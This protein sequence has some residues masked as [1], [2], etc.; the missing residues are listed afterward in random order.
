MIAVANNGFE[1]H[2]LGNR[3]R[4]VRRLGRGGMADV[5]LATDLLENMEVAVKVLKAEY[6]TDAE[7]LRRFE[8]EARAVSSLSHPNIVQ[9]YGIG[10]E[11]GIHYMVMEYIEGITLKELLQQ[12]VRLDW[13]A[14]VPIA[15]Q[16]GLALE[17]AHGKG[18]IHRDIKPQNIMI[19]PDVKAKVTDF[20]IAR[21][22]SANTITMTGGG[23]LGSVHYFSPEQARGG[24]VGEKSDIYSLGILLYELVTGVLPFDGDTSVSIAIKHLQENPQ[25]PSALQSHIPS[26]LDGIIMKCIQKSPDKRYANAGDLIAELDALMIDPDG[27]YGVLD[28]AQESSGTLKIGPVRQDPD[29]RKIGQI[30]STLNERRRSRRRDAIIV[31]ALV[32]VATVALVNIGVIAWR[33]FIARIPEPTSAQFEVGNYAGKDIEDVRVELDAAGLLQGTDFKTELVKDDNVPV[34]HVIRQTPTPGTMIGPESYIVLTLTVSGGPNLITLEDFTG[35]SYLVVQPRLETTLG[36]KVEIIKM[37]DKALGKDLIIRTEPGAG[38]NI[39]KGGSIK[40][41]V[42][43]GTGKVKITKDILGLTKPQLEAK[44][45]DLDLVLGAVET[46]PAAL[47]AIAE[48]KLTADQLVTIGVNFAFDTEINTKTPVTVR[49]GTTDEL[50]GI[51]NPS[52][53]PDPSATTGTTVPGATTAPPTP[54]PV[55]PTTPAPAPGAG[56]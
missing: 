19:T 11:N 36:L 46:S 35:Q 33:N 53:T 14:A 44:L 4:I 30:E 51:L 29:Y 32:L 5:Y 54:P 25:P 38:E 45:G 42:S 52:P 37:N 3:Y 1:G 55:V 47:T 10:E 2:V 16:I 20:G 23:A 39:N 13:D 34:G 31:I 27:E 22:S 56:G 9:V 48:N 8:S 28:H 17:H 15:I 43:D 12:C 40:V 26:G 7:F 41:Y 21:A 50:L 6:S 24:M 18:I 49:F